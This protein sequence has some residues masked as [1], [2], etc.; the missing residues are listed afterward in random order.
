MPALV[1]WAVPFIHVLEH[2]VRCVCCGEDALVRGD[3]GSCK[4][5]RIKAEQATSDKSVICLKSC[6]SKPSVLIFMELMLAPSI[7]FI[8]RVHPLSKQEAAK[9][10]L[11]QL[12][13]LDFHQ[14]RCHAERIV[15]KIPLTLL[16]TTKKH[17]GIYK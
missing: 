8:S 17:A 13:I 3:S 2:T 5:R 16:A 4:Q 6:S 7:T 10:F 1:L 12:S 11:V 9:L 15:L 14:V